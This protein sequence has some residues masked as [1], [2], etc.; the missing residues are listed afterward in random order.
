MRPITMGAMKVAKNKGPQGET[1]GM[2]A[3]N[4]GTTA[5]WACRHPMN[6]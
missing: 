1:R 3:A 4:Q 6:Q 2:P 5:P